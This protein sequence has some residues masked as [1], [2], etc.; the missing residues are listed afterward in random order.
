M[1]M[2]MADTELKRLENEL[3][4]KVTGEV[5]FDALARALY[6]TDASP[7]EIYPY[8]V[9]LPK[10]T[11]D[12]RQVLE[13]A[14]RLSL[15][16]LPRGGGTSLAG[17]TVGQ[18]IVLDFSKY[19][20]AILEVDPAARRAKV[21]PGVV[22]DRLNAY[23]EPYGLQFT[24]DVATSSR[25]TLGGMVAN[26]S[27]GTRSIKYGT[28][29]DQVLAMTVMLADGTV[30]E[31]APL[32]RQALAAK[33][34][35]EGLEG[36][37]YRQVHRIITTHAEDIR[38]RYPKVM[39]RNS[40]YSLDALLD[41][42][43]N[44]A[45]LICGS[46]GTLAIILDVTI[47]LEPLPNERRLALLHFKRQHHALEAVQ[48]INRH[49]PSAVEFMDAPLLALGR[50]NPHLAP[51]IG[52]LKGEPEAV[53]LVE[54]DGEDE[55]TLSAKLAALA[56]DPEVSAR[57]Y[58]VHEAYSER[59]Q[60]EIWSFR[61]S[62]LGIYETM[63]GD[64]KPVPLIE[65]AAV[66]V[67]HLPNYVAEV[68]AVCAKYGVKTI[69]YAHASVGLLHIRPILNLKSPDGVKLFARISDEVFALVV[70]YGG[71]WSG[72]HGDGLIRSYK[73]RELFG[74]AL[75]EAFRTLKRT[76]DPHNLLNP[77][78]IVD[79]PSPTDH[80]RFGPTY[81]LPQV[82]THLA[83]EDGL[84]QAVEACTGVGDCRKIGTGTMCP[85]YMATRDED[86]STRGRANA[87]REALLGRLPGGLSS[88]DL[89][90]VMDLCLLCKACKAECPSQ[91]DVAKLKTE[92]LAHYYAQHGT[93]LA[94]RAIGNV[95]RLAPLGRFFA[96][97]ANAL[98][99][100]K[101]V[102]WA[103][104]KTLGIDERRTLPRYADAS[105]EQLFRQRPT[106]TSSE[107]PTVAL[108]PDT[109]T[110]FHEP[111]VGMAAV[112]VL[113]ALGYRVE[114]IPYRCCGRPQLSKG[115]LGEA[116]RLA[117]KNVA[118]LHAYLARGVPI[119][120]LEPS[121]VTA[122]KDDY[123]DLIP[124]QAT[125]AVARHVLLIDQFLAKAWTNGTLKPQ[126]VFR[127]DGTPILLHGHCQQRAVLGTS[128]SRAVLGWLSSAVEEADAGCCGMAGSFGYDHHAL[129][130]Q[131]GEQRLFP[132]V[133]NHPGTVVAS[134]FSC[135]HQIQDGTGRQARHLVEV[136]AEGL[137]R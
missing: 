85:S 37:I 95:A 99:P 73:N 122:F 77:G 33:L 13:V 113:E 79:A 53:L 75:Y 9:V 35:L 48:F 123:R 71:A 16:L 94:V 67:E 54:F 115:L 109:W 93:P 103:L 7:Y 43:F 5:R 49:G 120:G 69:M 111:Q 104:A 121:C 25:A 83:F 2:V 133:R 61:R 55:A 31:F 20:D 102:R 90:R 62:G 68:Q 12:V 78:K 14:R 47:R 59:E 58:H 118:A 119:V 116:K 3:K 26:N 100:L 40:G 126:A 97:L 81:R 30:T 60:A 114:L 23:L 136:L 56:T 27:A 24:P 6:A 28:T 41:G 112:R 107:R 21:Q 76:F 137:K 86:H 108:L 130:M 110:M 84:D 89:Y 44:L 125:E 50:A 57:C 63:K 72:E 129:S 128:A 82:R 96:P 92:F 70:K 42:P 22:R 64:A 11:E 4:W 15:P 132:A 135:R 127:H 39:R 51:L 38:A 19:M 101:P 88:H 124:G 106:R 134:G 131:I 52:W 10:T 17:Q 80:L 65:D 66:P 1:T 34:Q 105:F 91:V 18:A 46:E 8:G 29:L 87:L 32:D 117:Q 45:K 74:E 36:D 98:L